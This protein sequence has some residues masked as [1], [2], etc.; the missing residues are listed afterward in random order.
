M[1]EPNPKLIGSVLIGFAIVAAAYTI[2]NFGQPSRPITGSQLGSAVSV[3]APIRQA[4]T[5][6]DSNNN[7]IE[8]WREEFLTARP[9]VIPRDTESTYQPPETVTE[10]VGLQFFEDILR[11]RGFG[12]F[13]PTQDEIIEQTL[14]SV[15]PFAFDQLID[16]DNIILIEATDTTIYRY[17]NDLMQIVIDNN[18][19]NIPDEITLLQRLLRDQTDE[20][21]AEQLAQKAAAYHR[22]RDMTINTP[23]PQFLAKEHL[24]LINSYNA[25]ARNIDAMVTSLEDPLVT[26]FRI[27]RYED[28]A[29]G[30]FLSFRNLYVTLEPYAAL[31]SVDDP[32]V[33]LVAFSPNLQ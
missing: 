3:S 25:I 13:A 26:I 21:A 20:V 9:V 4:I 27:K 23:V 6:V 7:G 22:K 33:L 32:A 29:T 10:Q 28:D 16:T 19:P 2:A 5:V 31:F 17:A 11:T 30:L 12:P 14:A 15:E 18:L 8:D 1:N 24:D